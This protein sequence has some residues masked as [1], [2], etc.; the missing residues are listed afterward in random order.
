MIIGLYDLEVFGSHIAN[1]WIDIGGSK[2]MVVVFMY[3]A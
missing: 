3:L 1:S 2:F